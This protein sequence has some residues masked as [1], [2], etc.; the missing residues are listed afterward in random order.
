MSNAWETWDS[1]PFGF[2]AMHVISGMRGAGCGGPGLH[3]SLR[4]IRE[5]MTSVQEFKTGWQH[6]KTVP[7]KKKKS[8]PGDTGLS[9]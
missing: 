8:R 4:G 5:K 1:L 2:L 3:P 6:S 9:F 7:L